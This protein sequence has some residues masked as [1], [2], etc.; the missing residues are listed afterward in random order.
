MTPGP[1]YP[2]TSDQIFERFHRL[3]HSRSR[4]DGGSGLGLAIARA[5]T[6]A[7]GGRIRAES[8]PGDGASFCITLPGYDTL[9]TTQH[10]AEPLPYR[11][12][13]S[14]GGGLS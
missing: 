9:Q 13:H 1:G 10:A 4:D 6:E 12:S 8:G 2:Q 5:T 3:D 14:V 7:H 11:S